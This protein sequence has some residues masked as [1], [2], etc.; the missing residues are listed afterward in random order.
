M[1]ETTSSLVPTDSR[2]LSKNQELI[3]VDFYS[4][5]SPETDADSFYVRQGRRSF[6]IRMAGIDAPEIA[7]H[8]AEE[9]KH[10]QKYGS[11]ATE[12]MRSI[13][14][15]SK[16]G[17][18][19][20]L[21]LTG[22]NTYGREVAVAFYQNKK[23]ELVN[24]NQELVKQK[25]AYLYTD[26][27]FLD[28]TVATPEMV[29]LYESYIQEG[30]SGKGIGIYSK[31]A[32]YPGTF[33]HSLA[34]RVGEPFQKALSAIGLSPKLPTTIEVEQERIKGKIGA[35]KASEAG[36]SEQLSTFFDND[37]QTNILLPSK[38]GASFF[39]D[40]AI[41]N[42]RM[43]NAGLATLRPQD[44]EGYATSA[45]KVKQVA[46]TGSLPTA[47]PWYVT[48]Y[49]QEINAPGLGYYLNEWSIS[50][51][52]GRF[53]REEEGALAS[54]AGG[55][56]KV[57]DKAYGYYASNTLDQQ[58][59]LQDANPNAVFKEPPVGF[60]EGAAT[61]TTNFAITTAGAV[62]T[63]F[64]LGIPYGYVTAEL[65]K[66]SMQGL[67]DAA[68]E[69]GSNVPVLGRKAA[70]FSALG[71]EFLQYKDSAELRNA[72][73]AK[74]VQAKKE[75]AP[76]GMYNTLETIA[77]LN[78][79]SQRRRA[80]ILFDN[81]ID[82]FISEIVN[83]YSPTVG[84]AIN[85]NWARLQDSL[86]SFGEELRK[87][88]YLAVEEGG[89]RIIFKNVGYERQKKVAKAV[90]DLLI[91]IPANITKW[92]WGRGT[93]SNPENFVRL[94][95]LFS[96]TDL[97]RTFEDSIFVD[98]IN[99]V[100]AKSEIINEE[101]LQGQI[102]GSFKSAANVPI[103]IISQGF[104]RFKQSFKL[105]NPL[106]AE[107][108]QLRKIQ[109]EMIQAGML[110]WEDAS[111]K[112][113][114]QTGGPPSSASAKQ[115]D[116]FF[117]Q[118]AKYQQK[119]SNPLKVNGVEREA[120]IGKLLE[121]ATNYSKEQNFKINK[122]RQTGRQINGADLFLGNRGVLWEVA[123]AG[124]IG[125]MILGD[126]LNA[127][128][129]SI[130]SQVINSLNKEEVAPAEFNATYLFSVSGALTGST[131]HIIDSALWS[132]TAIA[133]GWYLSQFTQGVELHDFKMGDG[134][135]DQLKKWAENSN[136]QIN[137][138]MRT[139]SDLAEQMIETLVTRGLPVVRGNRFRNFL[140]I[141][142][143]IL[144]AGRVATHLAAG[145]LNL[146][147]NIPFIGEAV[148]GRGDGLKPNENFILA[149]QLGG[150]RNEV[151][152]RYS[153]GTQVSDMEIQSAYFAGI[154]SNQ[155]SVIDK[156]KKAEE[157]RV[158]AKQAPLPVFQFFMTETI[159]GRKFNDD[160]TMYQ[161]GRVF[162]T[163]G[164][165]TAPVLGG[166]F[167]L[168]L[169]VGLNLDA[170]NPLGVS[171]V[172]N[173]Q[174]NNVVN[175][176]NAL[177]AMGS[178]AT[179]VALATIGLL[180][181][182]VG[183]LKLAKPLLFNKGSGAIEDL[184]E[185]SNFVK[186]SA[187]TFNSV[188]EGFIRLPQAG[189]NMVRGVMSA[190]M[191]F[192]NAIGRSVAYRP[193]VNQVPITQRITRGLLLGMVGLTA[194]RVAADLFTDD[195]KTIWN[196][197][198]VGGGLA[199]TG[200]LFSP[201]IA[202]FSSATTER[203]ARKLEW[204]SKVSKHFNYSNFRVPVRK[205]T[206]P[207][208]VSMAASY[209]MT[210]SWFQ[211]S[212][213]MDQDASTQL[214][215]IAA[216]TAVNSTVFI[217]ASDMGLTPGQTINKYEKY[218]KI[219]ESEGQG[220]I[221][222]ARK[223]Y[224]EYRS[225]QLYGDI[226]DYQSQIRQF[227]YRASRNA[228]SSLAKDV[229]TDDSV[230]QLKNT[231]EAM[232]E[233]LEETL[234][235]PAMRKGLGEIFDRPDMQR[236]LI[237]RGR[238]PS[239]VLRGVVALSATS[240]LFGA[241]AQAVGQMKGAYGQEGTNRFYETVDALPIIGKPLGGLFRLMTGM[242]KNITSTTDLIKNLQRDS[243]G[244]LIEQVGLRLIK[245]NDPQTLRLNRIVQDIL[246]PVVFDPANAYQSVLPFAG[247]TFRPDKEG[248]TR[249]GA[250]LQLQS[251]GQ[252]IST[253]VYSMAGNTLRAGMGRGE[254]GMIV[255][256][257]L[258]RIA[259]NTPMNQLSPQQMK[260][261][262]KSIRASTAQLS[263]LNP[264]QRRKFS[265]PMMDSDTNLVGSSTL[266]SLAIRERVRRTS[267][268]AAQ[269]YL[270]I[271]SRMSDTSDPSMLMGVANNIDPTNPLRAVNAGIQN[272]DNEA[273]LSTDLSALK[274]HVFNPLGRIVIKGFEIALDRKTKRIQT[275]P[276]AIEDTS[277]WV[278]YTS[279]FLDSAHEEP[280][281]DNVFVKVFQNIDG[282]LSNLPAASIF[283]PAVYLAGMVASG[284]LV[285]GAIASLAF[286]T[287][288]A[289]VLNSLEVPRT[290]FDVSKTDRVSAFWIHGSNL[291]GAANTPNHFEV[292]R[293]A[294]T[295]KITLPQG[296]DLTDKNIG[297]VQNELINAFGKVEV[298][299]QN[300]TYDLMD[301]IFEISQDLKWKGLVRGTSN[302]AN[303]V[304]G[305]LHL[306]LSSQFDNYVD[307]IFNQFLNTQINDV[308]LASMVSRSDMGGVAT[309]LKAELR[310]KIAKVL[311]KELAGGA[312]SKMS[313]QLLNRYVLTN[314]REMANYL[315]YLIFEEVSGLFKS[316]KENL[317]ILE[318]TDA[319]TNHK[320]ERRLM[321]EMAE[322]R[323]PLTP[324][325]TIKALKTQRSAYS[326]VLNADKYKNLDDVVVEGLDSLQGAA[327]TGR[328]RLSRSS[329]FRH[330]L[331]TAASI[332]GM[333]E[334][335][336]IFGSF[337]RLAAAQDNEDVTDAQER[338]TYQHA[339]KVLTNS[340]LGLAISWGSSKLL[341]N[342]DKIGKLI[343]KSK[344]KA[345][346]AAALIT[347]GF[348]F[349]RKWIKGAYEG[350]I[351][352]EPYKMFTNFIGSLTESVQEGLGRFTGDIVPGL[353]HTL[354]LGLIKKS[355]A[356][357][358]IGTGLAALSVAAVIANF[359]KIG[360][361]AML[362]VGAISGAVGAGL[363]L[364][365][366]YN[367]FTG[368]FTGNLAEK[369]AS[370]PGIGNMLITP[371]SQGIQDAGS[372]LGFE[373]GSPIY[374]ATAQQAIAQESQRY[375]I[376]AADP[377]GRR[378]K[379]LFV[380]ATYYGSTYK[381]TD[382]SAT[383]LG[384][385]AK[386][387]MDPLLERE[388]AIKAQYY[389]QSVLGSALWSNMIRGAENFEQLKKITKQQTLGDPRAKLMQKR[390]EGQQE[391]EVK[392]LQCSLKAKAKGQATKADAGLAASIFKAI[393]SFVPKKEDKLQKT[394][395]IPREQVQNNSLKQQAE[396][397]LQRYG[398]M[399]LLSTQTSAEDLDGTISISEGVAQHNDLLA[400]ITGGRVNPLAIQQQGYSF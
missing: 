18:T 345:A 96:F 113:L 368:G 17:N 82:P 381:E 212:S 379:G 299:V 61:F 241:V 384:S 361:G 306:N 259:G 356:T 12:K 136:F 337:S 59:L 166:N 162:Y 53:Y 65:F 207:V 16:S 344:G 88:I 307:D 117:N 270:S 75:Q 375:L 232:G 119:I 171:L 129:A 138:K 325:Q 52:Y 167:S 297:R 93:Y 365:P 168:G 223:L 163:A 335:V 268:L 371:F 199:F 363:S 13:L 351:S 290:L 370:I 287:E 92:S 143:G 359:T 145:G 176:L 373:P 239:R 175:Y 304:A 394:V 103:Q 94:G 191:D 216:Y 226:K 160:G 391:K 30:A 165:Q 50:Q 390:V 275:N 298:S 343:G 91:H 369:I 123:A 109:S 284:F 193:G 283:K 347:A 84:G 264:K 324:S 280:S 60:F 27:R 202:Q 302:M 128:G 40:M 31:D 251:A 257:H 86:N 387:F 214:A 97:L 8:T 395:V 184:M 341:R 104:D 221:N 22:E 146:I 38:H 233:N 229:A 169:P 319:S 206:L 156:N 332:F 101:S 90:D 115:L 124:L 159:K 213:G 183:A 108:R 77:G 41:F 69:Q 377:T 111:F 249:V 244:K 236:F 218:K 288:T 255:Q 21:Q 245:P 78:N 148:F 315:S 267:E 194:S 323:S 222:W 132:G 133:G 151:F 333:G 228:A 49:D 329:S 339:G 231:L 85:P 137:G 318:P 320:L 282:L 125:E 227:V 56:G 110:S 357:Q 107:A 39:Y 178:T 327:P 170:A 262:A 254:L 362:S 7:H 127:P 161:K 182:T 336:D 63:Y 215:T 45:Y 47:V 190:D 172:Y 158:I 308:S 99:K 25:A 187:K 331:G 120:P 9:T 130:F 186:A 376:A 95:E 174:A 68:L 204:S 134:V 293:G 150:F 386:S 122:L 197:G 385:P 322:G 46:L 210:S 140:F 5:N 66:T 67:L 378:T 321:E 350:M 114:L 71:A 353:V 340:A 208:A 265:N 189:F 126:M 276:L 286:K 279:V 121:K 352:S 388:L 305:Q 48:Q 355:T 330:I 334:A 173:D 274:A 80:G 248:G 180:E 131:N 292:S 301:S 235:N 149:A 74:I 70:V 112:R 277:E 374:V 196:V 217:K 89:D 348:V 195:Q 396:D 291:P 303:S 203:L 219:L 6:E 313:G 135:E 247:L 266:L 34:E 116:N 238:G 19:L 311:D 358:A 54:V 225:Q 36:F 198:A 76:P 98:G 230:K 153:S 382:G 211:Y 79:I 24:L 87:P 367:S 142:A 342:L 10:G 383:L 253:A 141:T 300:K 64:T 3:P 273:L 139:A 81:V 338:Y 58:A 15:D 258:T 20:F 73:A 314:E 252:D 392:E 155:F 346:I 35:V 310:E 250:Y 393:T 316:L 154:L 398:I 185:A 243:S 14:R 364:I 399:P 44:Q 72:V 397:L 237:G 200:G 205:H 389:N 312:G 246:A 400:E 278:Q 43:K 281:S 83:P 11:L 317:L 285:T 4:I 260:I 100:L 33:R 366:G 57:L 372:K 29:K 295:Y 269:P 42:A 360:T 380:N 220:P 51:G 26:P 144:G 105:L 32:L 28:K 224:A 240:V 349:G 296:I 62:F 106:L 354:S 157:V 234:Q 177:G 328:P 2:L 289:A 147:R 152:N 242:D 55:L 188:L 181:G 179:G 192:Y 256:R 326:N 294:Q 23:G 271:A 272:K 1:F 102:A 209:L 309:A 37:S 201:E 164:M 118:V 263:P 261:L